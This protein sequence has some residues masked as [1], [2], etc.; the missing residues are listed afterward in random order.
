VRRASGAGN[1]RRD[2]S[3]E[4]CTAGGL[5]VTAIIR[6]AENAVANRVTPQAPMVDKIRLL[7]E[8]WGAGIR[9]R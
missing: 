3:L 2:L 9:T 1:R 5:D 4:R 8:R 6:A 7:A